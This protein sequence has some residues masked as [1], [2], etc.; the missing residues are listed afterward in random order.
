VLSPGRDLRLQAT[1]TSIITCARVKII[2]LL[3]EVA[4]AVKNLLC[5]REA[6]SSNP[7]STK[8]KKIV[9]LNLSF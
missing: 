5:N 1:P 9:L 2:I 6:L 8:K 3:G 4:Q 7:S